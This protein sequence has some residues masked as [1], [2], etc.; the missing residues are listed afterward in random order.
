MT[1]LQFCFDRW[2]SL[3]SC[4][5]E[6]HHTVYKDNIAIQYLFRKSMVRASSGSAVNMMHTCIIFIYKIYIYIDVLIEFKEQHG[7]TQLRAWVS[8]HIMIHGYNIYIIYG[9]IIF[10]YSPKVRS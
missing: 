1:S 6:G 10:G 5:L 7:K 9:S 4:R 2:H 8:S 3:S